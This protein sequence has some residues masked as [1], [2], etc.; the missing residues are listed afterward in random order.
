VLGSEGAFI[1]KIGGRYHL[2]CAELNGQGTNATYDCMSA[3]SDTLLGPYGDRYLAIPHGGHNVLFED[4]DG[5]LW[6]TFF[7]NDPSAP[8][9]ERPAILRVT[10]DENGRLRPLALRNQPEPQTP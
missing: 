4:Q 10:I 7:G 9:R 2:F 1:R 8:F 5:N 3:H 6:S